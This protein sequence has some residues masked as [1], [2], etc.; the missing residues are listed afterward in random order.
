MKNKTLSYTA[1]DYDLEEPYEDME[2]IDLRLDAIVDT[3][4]YED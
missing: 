2:D 4:Y 3:Y 1:S